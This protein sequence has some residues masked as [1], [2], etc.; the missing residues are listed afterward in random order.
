MCDETAVRTRQYDWKEYLSWSLGDMTTRVG[1]SKW[2]LQ[3]A[4]ASKG[5]RKIQK[6][7]RNGA[8]V[9]GET[10]VRT[11]QYDWK[12][13]LSESLGDLTTRVGSGK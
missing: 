11:R 2:N 8:N 13:Y 4:K 9:C 5:H 7:T 12:E 3:D 10:A 1:S 6:S